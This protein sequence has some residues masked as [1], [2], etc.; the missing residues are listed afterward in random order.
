ALAYAKH[1]IRVNAVAPGW[2][3]TR[4]FAQEARTRGVT[5]AAYRKHVGAQD[6]IGRVGRP[7]EIANLVLFLASEDA[8]YITG[9]LVV[10]DGGYT[11][12]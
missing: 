5:V 4:M 11:A 10:A 3:E 9:D 1:G 12:R 8:A 7:E 6:P 2:V